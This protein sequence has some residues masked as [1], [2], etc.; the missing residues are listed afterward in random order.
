MRKFYEDPDGG[1]DY[2][3]RL[4]VYPGCVVGCGY[5]FAS[6][7]LFFTFNGERLPEAFRGLYVPRVAQDVYGNVW[8]NAG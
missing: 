1:R 3:P 5:E 7:V 6:G 4:K 8:C 2:A